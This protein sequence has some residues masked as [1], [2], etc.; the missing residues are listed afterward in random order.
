MPDSTISPGRPLLRDISRRTGEQGA[1]A[2]RRTSPGTTAAAG[3]VRAHGGGPGSIAQAERGELRWRDIQWVDFT[4]ESDSGMEPGAELRPAP[5]PVPT[6]TT[7]QPADAPREIPPLGTLLRRLAETAPASPAT[8]KG[9]AIPGLAPRFTRLQVPRLLPQTRS[10]AGPAA[11][12]EPQLPMQVARTAP[13]VEPASVIVP[14]RAPSTIS[15]PPLAASPPPPRPPAPLPATEAEEHE[16]TDRE[17][18]LPASNSTRVTTGAQTPVPIS[19]WR[20]AMTAGAIAAGDTLRQ[21]SVTAGSGLARARAVVPRRMRVEPAQTERSA[22]RERFSA[23]VGQ[24]LRYA[25]AREN[26]LRVSGMAVLG[27]VLVALIAYVGGAVIVRVAEPN[28]ASTPTPTPSPA[29]TPAT[30]AIGKQLAT[31]D[32][33]LH[34]GPAA[35]P[36]AAPADEP[37]TDPAARAAFYITRAK[38]GDAAA[39]YDVGV[40]YA[41]GRGLVQDYASAATW[42]RAAAAQ[43]NVAAEYNLGVLYAQGLGVTAN[44]TEA[45]NWFRSAADQNHPAAQFNLGLAYATGSGAKQD[46]AA[47][48]RWYQ[49]AA[50][51]GLA[52]AM[53]NLA[54]LYEAGNGVERSPVDAYAWYRAAGE[55]GDATAKAYAAQLF[56]QF[57]DKDKAR[58]E[59]LAATIGSALDSF[60]GTA[61]PA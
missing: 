4:S 41:Q 25:A 9:E 52:P 21:V 23:A 27:V 59:G 34:P 56:Q 17:A 26:R 48:A 38:A 49:R 60:T 3:R 29:G 5:E 39:Q 15:T 2:L 7:A 43:G 12:I 18:P 36:A 46:F 22:A 61:P 53:V 47:A 1:G 51:Q 37:P 8:P 45:I 11:L 33:A 6:P 58:A 32:K 42:F 57:N 13:V 50:A 24:V 40:L 30:D 20:L 19:G 28:I 54:I 31:A 35:S 55:R 10:P 14:P 44:A 16:P